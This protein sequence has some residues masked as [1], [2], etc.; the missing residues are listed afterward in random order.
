MKVN[1]RPRSFGT[2]RFSLT[3]T[4]KSIILWFGLFSLYFNVFLLLLFFFLVMRMS[5]L[6]LADVQDFLDPTLDTS[7][8]KI[9]SH[10]Q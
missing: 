3:M 6:C 4:I 2:A 7:P 8:L 10:L 1:G 5:S 9:S